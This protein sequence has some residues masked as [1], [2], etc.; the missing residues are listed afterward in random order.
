M[1]GIMPEKN[2]ASKSSQMAAVMRNWRAIEHIDSP[3]EEVIAAALTKDRDAINLLAPDYQAILLAEDPRLA[4]Y[5]SAPS[6]DLVVRMTEV[7]QIIED[8]LLISKISNQ[9]EALQIFALEKEYG[10]GYRHPSMVS[11]LDS[12][13]ERVLIRAAKLDGESIQYMSSPSEAVQLAAVQQNMKV[14]RCIRNPSE[15]VQAAA[16]RETGM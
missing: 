10:A 11:E 4:Q 15:A 13:T 7:I 8:P 1:E 3:Y 16:V 6:R 2:Y 14:I 5:I 9:T 12:P